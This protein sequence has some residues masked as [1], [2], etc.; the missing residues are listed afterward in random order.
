MN[1]DQIIGFDNIEN[2]VKACGD[3]YID[4]D[5]ILHNELSKCK[6]L[7]MEKVLINHMLNNNYWD[8]DYSNIVESLCITI[9][10]E[11]HGTIFNISDICLSFLPYMAHKMS[12]PSYLDMKWEDIPFHKFENAFSFI[13]HQALLDLIMVMYQIYPWPPY[14]LLEI[15]NFSNIPIFVYDEYQLTDKQ[16]IDLISSIKKSIDNVYINNNIDISKRLIK[17]KSATFTQNSSWELD[18]KMEDLKKAGLSFP[19]EE[20]L[21]Y[22]KVQAAFTKIWEEKNKRRKL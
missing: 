8:D 15:I 2:Y 7:I 17:F 14:I 4:W 20:V 22:L 16:K 5:M 9:L 1:I 19:E 3:Y 21:T 18:W 10:E 12:I 13:I 6:S 11:S